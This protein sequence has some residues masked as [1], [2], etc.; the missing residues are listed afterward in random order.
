MFPEVPTERDIRGDWQRT[1]AIGSRLVLRHFMGNFART[2]AAFG[3]RG[4]TRARFRQ[5]PTEGSGGRAPRFLPS[6]FGDS[7]QNSKN[8]DGS[9]RPPQTRVRQGLTGGAGFRAPHS[10]PSVYA[11][12]C[13]D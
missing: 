9:R 1:A 4:S 13:R 7:C 12:Y 5:G 8:F 3:P 11:D 10:S 2:A 6:V